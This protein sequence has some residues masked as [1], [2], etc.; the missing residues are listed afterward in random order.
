MAKKIV[1][2]EVMVSIIGIR[3]KVVKLSILY[4]IMVKI[5]PMHIKFFMIFNF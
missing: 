1:N 5:F 3:I 2:F 4:T